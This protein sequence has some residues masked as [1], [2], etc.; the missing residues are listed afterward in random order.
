MSRSLS[1][2]APK[3]DWSALLDQAREADRQLTPEELDLWRRGVLDGCANGWHVDMVHAL[4]RA[5]EARD[6]GE[7]L[8]MLDAGIPVAAFLA[9]VL[10]DVMRTMAER[11]AAGR[12]ASFTT[13]QDQNLRQMFVQ[14]TGHDSRMSDRAAIEW[15][16][17]AMCVSADTVRRSLKRTA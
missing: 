2:R 12:P 6:T 3:H 9:A 4:Q 10:G 14:L 5:L 13:A 11:T 7:L 8:A 1:P 15:L 16:A 17:R